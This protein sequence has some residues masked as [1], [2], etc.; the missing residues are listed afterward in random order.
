MG[1]SQHALI[2]LAV[3]SALACGE[4]SVTTESPD[5]ADDTAAIETLVGQYA[6]AVSAEPVDIALAGEV[7]LD[8]P[9]VLFIHPAGRQRGWDV[10]RDEVYLKLMGET[11]SRRQL[12]P[13]QVEVGLFGDTA[14]AEFSWVFD[15]TFRKDRG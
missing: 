6:E 3:A 11:F 12:V 9:D 1:I 2:A 10:I 15:A 7:W 8:S 14:V 5:A 4:S 13:R